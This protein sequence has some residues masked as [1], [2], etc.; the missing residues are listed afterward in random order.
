MQH[1][2]EFLVKGMGQEFISKRIFDHHNIYQIEK[3]TRFLL[4]SESGGRKDH[5][6]LE[7]R[8]CVIEELSYCMMKRVLF[9]YCAGTYASGSFDH[10]HTRPC[11]SL[12]ISPPSASIS[13][14]PR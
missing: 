13:E 5:R 12:E 11:L 1:F 6:I 7:L 4:N 3:G 14:F 2:Q 8:R 9:E 10:R